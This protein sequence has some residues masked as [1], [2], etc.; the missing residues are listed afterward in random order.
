MP[1]KITKTKAD[2][3]KKVFLCGKINLSQFFKSVKLTKYQQWIDFRRNRASLS[4][5]QYQEIKSEIEKIRNAL[6]KVECSSE[7]GRQLGIFIRNHPQLK[8]SI[9]FDKNANRF[10]VG[11]PSVIDE[12][13]YRHRIRLF[14]RETE[15]W[16]KRSF[17]Y[18]QSF[19]DFDSTNLIL[20]I[21]KSWNFL[22]I[23]WK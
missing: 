12:M 1:Q 11:R 6:I 3:I 10:K 20:F 21:S 18:C 15:L 5:D 19:P 23:H 4:D 9:L 22:L 13:F 8:T 14:L 17:V 16:H 7:F 2:Q